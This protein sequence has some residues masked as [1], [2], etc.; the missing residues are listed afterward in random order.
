M[1]YSFLEN[2]ATYAVWGMAW[3]K[4]PMRVVVSCDKP[5]RGAYIL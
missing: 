5:G 4:L 2:I 3:L 1:Y